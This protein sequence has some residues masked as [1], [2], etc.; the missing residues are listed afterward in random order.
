MCDGRRE[1]CDRGNLGCTGEFSLSLPE[2]VFCTL[3]FVNIKTEAVP[4]D[5][6]AV[7]SLSLLRPCAGATDK[8]RPFGEAWQ[9][10]CTVRQSRSSVSTLEARLSR[11]SGWMV[12]MIAEV[13]ELRNT[14][15]NKFG[16]FPID[17]SEPPSWIIAPEHGGDGL[18][19]LA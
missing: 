11:S 1:F 9:R 4:L 18:D 7:G 16:G 10:G 2:P 3:R 8:P 5:N 14:Q 17:V 19:K 6:V 12:F 15:A 13:R